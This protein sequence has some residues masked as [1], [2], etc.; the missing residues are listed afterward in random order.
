MANSQHGPQGNLQSDCCVQRSQPRETTHTVLPP[1]VAATVGCSGT[2]L[3]DREE[4]GPMVELTSTES[5]RG[6]SR[7]VVAP[8]PH[9][10]L[11]S[12]GSLGTGGH[13]VVHG[14][15]ELVLAVRA[16]ADK[17]NFDHLLTQFAEPVSVG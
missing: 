7:D 13:A 10:D 2:S 5:R 9:Q 3:P 11:L 4:T 17:F 1:T 12:P 14:V 8:V 6:M 15:P 16:G